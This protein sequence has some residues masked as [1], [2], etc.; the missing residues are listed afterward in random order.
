LAELPSAAR[1][2]LDTLVEA[3]LLSRHTKVGENSE[4]L[5]E[6]SHEALFK[7][8]PL[9][10]NSLNEERAFLAG[11]AQ[12]ARL[13]Q[14]WQA[15]PARQKSAALLSGLN[16]TRSRQ[17]L[18]THRTGLSDAEVSFIKASERGQRARNMTVCALVSATLLVLAGAGAKWGYAEYIRRT[19]LDCDILAAEPENNVFVPGV[20]YDRI[21]TKAA[22]PACEE[23]VKLD[24]GNPRLIH[25]FARSLDAAGRFDDA[26]Y[27][28]R[29]AADQG[30][31]WSQNNL[32]VLY[33]YGRGVPLDFKRGV[34]LLRTAAEQN[35]V[36]AKANYQGQDFSTIFRDDPTRPTIIQNALIERGLLRLQHLN[37]AWGSPTEAA[38]EAFKRLARLPDRG[39]TLRVIDTLGIVD[40]ISATIRIGQGGG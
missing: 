12:L 19:S 32:G 38:L 22:I 2:L 7:A 9:L 20:E 5:I 33:F 35:N 40:N 29:Q 1:R 18:K 36:N 13:L 39:I 30:W 34:D 23:A 21:D 11:K 10:W 17:W 16:L 27:W 14:D 24:A 37:G 6:V 4:V 8:W 25:N 26:A 3:R 31:A 15:A 28:Y